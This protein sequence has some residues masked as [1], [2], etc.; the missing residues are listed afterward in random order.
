VL[1]FFARNPGEFFFE[2]AQFLQNLP[3]GQLIDRVHSLPS[4][5]LNFG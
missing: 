5:A 1:A 4:I 3:P 2:T